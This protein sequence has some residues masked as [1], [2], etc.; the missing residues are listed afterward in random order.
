[1]FK[2]VFCAT[3]RHQKN[4]TSP[5]SL[6]IALLCC[7]NDTPRMLSGK[8]FVRTFHFLFSPAKAKLKQA[9]IKKSFAF[10][11]MAGALATTSCDPKAGGNVGVEPAGAE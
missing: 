9:L 10:L 8:R 6:T 2:F 1:M 3:N 5:F 11:L 7:G 4:L